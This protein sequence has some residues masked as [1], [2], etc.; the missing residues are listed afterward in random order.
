MQVIYMD[1]L[2]IHYSGKN[3]GLLQRVG[4]YSRISLSIA[5]FFLSIN[6]IN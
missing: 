6:I 4:K 5:D 3:A 2:K 1:I